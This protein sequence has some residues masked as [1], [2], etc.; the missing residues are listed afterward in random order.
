[1]YAA[2]QAFHDAVRNGNPQMPLLIFED[3]VFSS[4]DIDV[5]AGIEFDDNFNMEEDIAIG[6]ATSNEIRFTL[7]NDLRLLNEFEFGEFVA[8][9]GVQIGTETYHQNGPVMLTTGN[10]SY[11]SSSSR[12]YLKRGDMALA[13]QP[14]SRVRCMMARDGKVYVFTE[15]GN[16]KVYDDATGADI[17]SGNPLNDFMLNKGRRLNGHG[18]YLNG[19]ILHDFYGG[20]K[21]VYEFVPLGTFLAERPKVPDQIRVEMTC[22]DRMTKFDVDMPEAAEL[23]I[24]YPCTVAQLLNK[25]CLYLNVPVDMGDGFINSELI[26]QK[27][28]E[29]FK[30][31]TM[32]QVLMWIAEAAGINARFNR[33]GVLILDWLHEDTGQEYD[34]HDYMDMQQTWYET[35]VIDKLYNRDSQGSSEKTYGSGDVGYLI[36]DNPILKGI[37]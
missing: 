3:A 28:P 20:K 10:A 37:A 15:S 32:R 12:P 2:S 18:Y 1:M 36:M 27:Q 29:D 31:A 9:L 4:M 14:D 17:T 21:Y 13:V 24:T 25:M 19:N 34:E 26:I 35:P 5:D 33:D 11:I 7:I 6:Q 22:Y 8:T 16:P 23:Q 30:N